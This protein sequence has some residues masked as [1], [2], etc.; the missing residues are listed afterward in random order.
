MSFIPINREEAISYLRELGNTDIEMNHYIET[1][2]IMKKL[3]NYFSEDEDY[4]GM[5][6]L[7]HDIDW[8][9]TKNRIQEHSLI[10]KDLLSRLGF[11]N[12]FISLVQSHVYSNET[13]PKF[14]DKK[15]TNRIEFCLASSETITGLIYAYSLMRNKNISTMEVKGLKKKFKDKTFA[16]NCNRKI[17]EEIE[18]TGISLDLFFQ[19][20]IDSLREI[21]D[22]IGLN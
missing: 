2:A 18:K 4:W 12:K 1:E 5:L 7:L 14:L 13:I 3:A 6:G 22:E 8:V 9:L 20:A 15:R 16:E 11:D 17:I 10:A 19:I 21:K